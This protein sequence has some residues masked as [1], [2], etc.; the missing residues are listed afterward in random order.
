MYRNYVWALNEHKEVKRA[1]RI[2]EERHVYINTRCVYTHMAGIQDQCLCPLR[3]YPCGLALQI[4]NIYS[5]LIHERPRLESLEAL[6]RSCFVLQ[7]QAHV[8]CIPCYT[9][10]CAVVAAE[11]S[12]LDIHEMLHSMAQTPSIFFCD[13]WEDAEM[14]DVLCYLMN[15]QKNSWSAPAEQVINMLP[16]SAFLHEPIECDFVG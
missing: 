11:A 8:L 3:I 14:G 12:E 2:G 6:A 10:L 1:G 9:V 5:K 7:Q 13:V 16:W 15:K 4:A